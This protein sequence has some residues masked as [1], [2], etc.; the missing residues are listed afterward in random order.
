[1]HIDENACAA[2]RYARGEKY[3]SAVK[4]LV[5]RTNWINLKTLYKIKEAKHKKRSTVYSSSYEIL[6][7]AK[8]Q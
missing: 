1:M 5:Q 6:E 7:K 3:Y 8:L 4:L 2:S